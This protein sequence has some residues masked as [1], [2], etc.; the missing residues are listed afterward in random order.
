MNLYIRHRSGV[1]INFISNLSELKQFEDSYLPGRH[2]VLGDLSLFTPTMILHLLKFIEENSDIDCYSS[3]DIKDPILLSRFVNVYK[4]P[5]CL[6][7]TY[8]LDEFNDSDK[9]YSSAESL[10]DGTSD[11]IKLRISRVN[12]NL[13]K[14]L[15]SL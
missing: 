14:L 6:V 10:L 15:L 9:S 5:L 12:S 7:K 8:S 3:S 13:S 1:W 11:D 4:E 2:L